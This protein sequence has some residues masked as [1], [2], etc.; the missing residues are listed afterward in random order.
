MTMGALP[1]F[2]HCVFKSSHPVVTPQDGRSNTLIGVVPPSTT[3]FDGV[4]SL[5]VLGGLVRCAVA[6]R[7]RVKPTPRKTET[8][9]S[10]DIANLLN[11]LRGVVAEKPCLVGG[12]AP[13]S[14]PV[15]LHA[16]A[17]STYRTLSATNSGLNASGHAAP[18]WINTMDKVNLADKFAKISEYWKPYIAAELNGQ[19]VKLD[20]LKGQFG[21]HHHYRQDEIFLVVKGRF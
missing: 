16:K 13:R 5:F 1:Y 6:C 17:F 12:P 14:I 3:C 9:N 7:V 8:A 11:V 10:L 18:I 21:F 20:K 19:H 4:I 15:F 2:G